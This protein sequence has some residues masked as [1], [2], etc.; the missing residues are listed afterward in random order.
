MNARRV[1]SKSIFGVIGAAWSVSVYSDV[2]YY[3]GAGIDPQAGGVTVGAVTMSDDPEEDAQFAAAIGVIL[4]EAS[5]PGWSGSG[6]FAAAE[7]PDEVTAAS[8][9]TNHIQSCTNGWYYGQSEHYIYYFGLGWSDPFTRSVNK[10]I[11]GCV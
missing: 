10:Y 9:D 11:N 2:L 8:W 5:G 6:G 3:I 4:T 1:L 7:L